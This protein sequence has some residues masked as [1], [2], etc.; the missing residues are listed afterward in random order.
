MRRGDP[1]VPVQSRSRPCRTV[2]CMSRR[3]GYFISLTVDG[4]YAETDGGLTPF[5]PADDEHRYANELV[6]AAGDIVTGRGMYDVMA[7][8]DELDVDDPATGDVE[9]EFATYWRATPKHVVSR[10]E[11]HLRADAEQ[12]A[13]DVVS[14]V[15][16][17]KAGDGPPIMLGAGADLFA[18]LAEADLI[19]DFR[20]LLVPTALGQGKAM[21]ASLTRPL[22]LRPTGSRTF[23][24][25]NVLMEYVRADEPVS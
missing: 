24:S 3:L 7:Y 20:F 13:G 6:H 15:R 4:M 12:L 21:F 17:M 23:E 22:L 25:G 1:D 8:W 2:A 10:G 9:R 11:P 14:A 19:D 5:E 18:T 16:T